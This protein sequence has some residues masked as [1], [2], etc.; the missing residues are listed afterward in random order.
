M[1]TI[2]TAN[3]IE[4]ASIASTCTKHAAARTFLNTEQWTH[5][6]QNAMLFAIACSLCS[7]SR[8]LPLT[9]HF[10]CWLLWM[11][12]KYWWLELWSCAL[13]V[14]VWCCFMRCPS[15]SLVVFISLVLHFFSSLLL[16]PFFSVHDGDRFEA[17]KQF[18]STEDQVMWHFVLG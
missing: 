13:V 15:V 16:L 14:W 18:Y 9:L 6:H 7:Q 4:S 8:S 12:S 3:T 10:I 1:W 5:T 2:I 17:C 11:H